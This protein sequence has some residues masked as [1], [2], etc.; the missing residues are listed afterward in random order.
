MVRTL[1]QRLL[2]MVLTLWLVSVVAF[3][4]IQLPPAT[5]PRPT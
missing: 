1:L 2:Y 4:V 3:V 5:T